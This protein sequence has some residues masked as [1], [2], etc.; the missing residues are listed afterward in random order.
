MYNFYNIEGGGSILTDSNK[1]KIHENITHNLKI[2][3]YK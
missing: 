1:N 3:F 2:R